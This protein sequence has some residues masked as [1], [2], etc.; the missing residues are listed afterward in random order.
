MPYAM[1]DKLSKIRGASKYSGNAK[2]AFIHA[3][4]SCY[5]KG[6]EDARCYKIGHAA[7]K[8]AGSKKGPAK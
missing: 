2:R 5:Q 6:G 3:F 1:D 8:Q 4:N 7:A